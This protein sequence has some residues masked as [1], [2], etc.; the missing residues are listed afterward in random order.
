[1]A[2]QNFE[3]SFIFTKVG[4]VLSVKKAVNRFIVLFYF[5][6]PLSLSLYESL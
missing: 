1:M 2:Y 4:Y 3:T 5:F 6:S